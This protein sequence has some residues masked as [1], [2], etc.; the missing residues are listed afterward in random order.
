M[1]KRINAFGLLIGFTI[2]GCATSPAPTTSVVEAPRN[3]STVQILEEICFTIIEDEKVGI[4][5]QLEYD[6]ALRDLEQGRH[7]EGVAALERI[8]AT[9]PNLT[10]PLI[11]LGIAY[12]SSGDL[13]EAEA[14]LQQAVALNPEHPSAHNELGIIYRKTGRFAEARQSYQAALAVYPGYHHARRNLAILC[15]LYLADLSCALE[16]Y[17]AY[18]QTVPEDKEA[19]M[20]IADLRG[21]LGR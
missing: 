7:E 17:E 15:D 1:K 3:Q 6:A 13:E 19:E 20:W 11:D 5:V 18:M 12:H 8:A 2:A 14:Y 4:D 16:N 9:S 21:R 10:A